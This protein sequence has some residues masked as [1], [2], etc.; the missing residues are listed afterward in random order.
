VHEHHHEHD[1]DHHGGLSGDHW[2]AMLDHLV[3]EAELLLPVLAGALD[4]ITHDVGHAIDV[5]SGPGVAT[6]AIAERYPN[7][8]VVAVDASQPLLDVVSERATQRGVSERVSTHLAVIPDGLGALPQADLVWASMALHHVGDEVDALRRFAQLMRPGATLVLVE[9]TDEGNV[10]IDDSQ[11]EGLRQRMRTAWSDWFNEMRAGLP[12]AVP[13]ADL[14]S[15][16]TSAGLRVT[17]DRIERVHVAAG[18]AT[19]TV[20][21]GHVRMAR[22]SL[23]DRL[24][25]GDLAALDAIAGSRMS[26]VEM[27]FARRVVTAVRDA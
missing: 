22:R 18:P 26:G 7:A 10:V 4:R 11:T 1:H 3:I 8:H 5:G 2:V 15:M 24:D 17:D 9:I 25:T 14:A 21:L 27:T 19:S 16:V 12:G 6:C 23:A 20:A 13:S